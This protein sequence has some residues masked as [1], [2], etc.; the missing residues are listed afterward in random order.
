MDIISLTGVISIAT[1]YL[2]VVFAVFCIVDFLSYRTRK[3]LLVSLFY[4]FLSPI[5]LLIFAYSLLF[6]YGS[7]ILTNPIF[8]MSY[9]NLL[10]SCLLH[11][12][13]GFIISGI[14]LRNVILERIL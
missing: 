14:Y 8:S 7:G 12:L 6:T 5:I 3:V 11:L 1:Q 2:A 13:F 4:L 9:N 10:I